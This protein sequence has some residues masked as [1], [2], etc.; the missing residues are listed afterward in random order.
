LRRATIQ[1]VFA[2]TFQTAI[3]VIARSDSDEAI[4]LSLRGEMD[5]FASLAMTEDGAAPDTAVIL[6][7]GGGSSTPRLLGFVI[8][9]S[10]IL[11]R[12]VKPDDDS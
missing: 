5:C 10:G 9:V 7:E 1:F 8:G 12:P 2:F 11:G 4:H 3:A 6:R